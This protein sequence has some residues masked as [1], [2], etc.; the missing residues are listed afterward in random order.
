[1]SIASGTM[2]A[3]RGRPHRWVGDGLLYS[4]HKARWSPLLEAF[5][6]PRLSTALRCAVLS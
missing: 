1:M 3:V 4:T 2:N 6:F 5:I